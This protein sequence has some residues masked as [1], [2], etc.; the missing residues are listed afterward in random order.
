MESIN[1]ILKQFLASIGLYG[2]VKEQTCFMCKGSLTDL[3]LTNR[4]YSF[5]KLI[6][7]KL[8][9]VIIIIWSI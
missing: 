9:L 8:V 1:T 4:N 7:L 2:L 6:C 3:I 5:K